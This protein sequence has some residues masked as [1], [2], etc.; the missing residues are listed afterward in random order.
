MNQ[1]ACSRFIGKVSSVELS[2]SNRYVNA[3]PTA[4]AMA[5]DWPAYARLVAV[6]PAGQSVAAYTTS[7]DTTS[8]D[9]PTILVYPGLRMLLRYAVVFI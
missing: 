2:Q 3:G 7:G 1:A 6:A 5:T 4:I 8:R 9:R